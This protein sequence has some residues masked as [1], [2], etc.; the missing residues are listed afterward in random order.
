MDLETILSQVIKA[1]YVV[2]APKSRL[3]LESSA[4]EDRLQRAVPLED[5]VILAAF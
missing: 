3:H 4:E 5:K 1:E 2:S